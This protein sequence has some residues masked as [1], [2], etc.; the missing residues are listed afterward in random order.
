[1]KK[2]IFFFTVVA[3]LISCKKDISSPQEL[4]GVSKSTH[5]KYEQP[6]RINYMTMGNDTMHFSYTPSGDP[7]KIEDPEQRSPSYYFTYDKNKRLVEVLSAWYN[8]D[9]INYTARFYY[10]GN[11]V[12]TDSVSSSAFNSYR[13]GNY[14]YDKYDR[15]IEYNYTFGQFDGTEVE[16]DTVRYNYPGENPYIGNRNYLAGNRVLMFLQKY[17]DKNTP[18]TS[19]NIFGYPT[20]FEIARPLFCCFDVDEIVYD[21]SGAKNIQQPIE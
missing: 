8:G 16:M 7:D 1:M 6:C 20:H 2:A 4:R 12:I 19:Y 9:N 15:I 21:C 14:V 11:K 13:I 10:Q 5:G 18:A 3:F 17:Y